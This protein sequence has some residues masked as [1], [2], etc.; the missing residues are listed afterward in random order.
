VLYTIDLNYIIIIKIMK[1]TSNVTVWV[2]NIILLLTLV[3]ITVPLAHA[4]MTLNI[5][6][7][8]ADK[9]YGGE[10]LGTVLVVPKEHVLSV[11]ANMSA[12]PTNGTVYEGWLV[13]DGGSGY[14]LSLGEFS[15]NG[16]LTYQ[17]QMVNPYTYTQFIVT[18][19]PFED[20]DPNA[21]TAT[22]RTQLHA[23][24]GR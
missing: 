18:E 13:D 16:T 15:K 4:Q 9:P 14:K 21:A 20:P 24:F 7:A 12:Q 17:D 19:E 22:G 23:P 3:A 2:S 10:K 6:K 5:T 8:D 1:S 11:T